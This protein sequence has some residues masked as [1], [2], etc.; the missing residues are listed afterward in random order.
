M[1]IDIIITN[2]HNNQN[3]LDKI[4]E[5]LENDNSISIR[6]LSRGKTKSMAIVK[7]EKDGIHRRV[8][9][10]YTS[11]QEYPFAL[12]YFTGSKVFN[13]V[14]RQKAN[15]LGL[16]LNEHEL[17]FKQQG[18]KGKKL[19][20]IFN[21]EKEILNYLGIEYLEPTERENAKK[22]KFIDIIEE[23][24]PEKET[25]KIEKEKQQLGL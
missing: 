25:V 17:S 20:K 12:L 15:D 9:F 10:L 22:I 2:I 1:G 19:D 4:L 3:T 24:L 13:T 8:D 23:T 18:I 11:P 6:F 5:G 14:V 21:S 16:T 7:I